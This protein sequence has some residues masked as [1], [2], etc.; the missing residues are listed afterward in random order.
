MKKSI[1]F[2]VLPVVVLA[3]GCGSNTGTQ[4]SPET[5]NSYQ[6]TE[7]VFMEKDIKIKYPQIEGLI[8]SA[9][10]EKINK[11]IEADVLYGI[12]EDTGENLNLNLAY[13]IR[14]K[15]ADTLSIEYDGEGYNENASYP[16]N[17]Y[18]T[19]N[20]D[21]KS[22]EKIKLTDVV[23][24][25]DSLVKKFRRSKYIDRGFTDNET[26]AKELQSAVCEYVT[27][28]GDEDLIGYFKQSG[29]R[30]MEEN[31]SCTFFSL[32]EDS[33]IISINVPHVLGDHAEFELER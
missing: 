2:L 33:I 13:K 14:L 30:N 24:A 26:S 1:L 17:W 3:T 16:V 9:K 5:K 29:S 11:L 27:G 23:A 21:V 8:D 18:F 25:D 10:E 19:T 22:G 32:S 7:K 4:K 31:P 6:I 28:I 12:E 20:I 15:S